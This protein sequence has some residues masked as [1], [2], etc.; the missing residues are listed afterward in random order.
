MMLHHTIASNFSKELTDKF[1]DKYI[2]P[3]GVLPS[4]SQIS[5]AVEK[6]FIIEDVHNFGPDYDKTL[7]AWHKN[8]NSKWD[9]IP[10]YD[11]RFRRMWNYYLS[12][13]AAG[14]KSR[15]LQLLQVVFRPM[16]ASGKYESVR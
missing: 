11:L 14:F 10:N 13:S 6:L 1:F 8:I 9:E 3:G 15:N 2:F 16:H 5:S 7:M 4:L 12:G